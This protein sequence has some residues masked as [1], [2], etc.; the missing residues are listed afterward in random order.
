[1]KI[2]TFFLAIS[3][4]VAFST[5]KLASSIHVNEVSRRGFVDGVVSVAAISLL[6]P[7][8]AFAADDIAPINGIYA[9]PNHKNGYRVVRTIGKTSASV[10]LQDEP[11]GPIITVSGDINTSGKGTTVTLDLSP[12]GGP[13]DVVAIVKGS[14]LYFPDGN[15][16]TKNSGVDGIYSDPNHPDGYRVVRASSGGNVMITLQDEP[17]GPMVELVGKRS[18]NG[19][20]LID[21]SP[22]GGPKDLAASFKGDKLVFPD[23]NAWPKL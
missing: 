14:D 8:S 10:T 15:S 4:T 3:S 2:I 11:E 22:K 1:M 9:D 12:K 5:P 16:W 6:Q 19:D 18:S 7:S 21:F 17:S 13:K 20:I 23:G